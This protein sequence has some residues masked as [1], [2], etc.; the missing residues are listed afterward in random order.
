MVVTSK[1]NFKMKKVLFCGCSYTS[2][3]GFEL[4]SKEPQLWVNLLHQ[5]GKFSGC[6]LVNVALSGR[7]N[8]GIFQDAVY[9]LTLNHYDYAVVAWTSMPR[10]ELDLGIETHSTRCVFHP[11]GIMRDVWCSDISYSKEYLQE[12]NNR[13]TT[14]AS[15][16]REISNLIYY[17]NALINLSNK[18]QTKIFFVNS[19][20]PWD[21]NYF[22]KVKAQLP[23]N[24]T[25]FTKQILYA[26]HRDDEAVFVLYNKIHQEYEQAGGI[27]QQHWLNL[28]SS[29]Q[30]LKIDVASDNRHPG[31]KSNHIYFELLNSQIAL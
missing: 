4:G 1:T 14:L 10:Y 8:S 25:D 29:Q 2:G 18:I 11:N 7:S 27:Q 13:L 15:Y 30:S 21:N 26:E 31:I 17:V 12:I 24:Y 16:H 20:C 22:K 5:Q 6:E 9:N 3:V 19:M 23:S 28:Y